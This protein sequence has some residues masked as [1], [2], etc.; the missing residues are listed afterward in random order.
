MLRPITRLDRR[1]EVLMV[2][3]ALAL[4]TFL[5]GGCARQDVRENSSVLIKQTPPTHNL[6]GIEGV[7]AWSGRTGR[8]MDASDTQGMLASADV[9]LVGE[10]HADETGH[11]VELALFEEVLRIESGTTLSMEMLERDEQHLVDR[12]LNGEIKTDD[13]VEQTHSANWGAT[14]RWGDWYQPVIDLAKKHNCPVVAANAPRR[15]VKRARREGYDALRALPQEERRWFCVPE[16]VLVGRYRERFEQKMVEHSMPSNL[17]NSRSAGPSSK[18]ML[19]HDAM[20]RSQLLWDCTMA[21][22]IARVLDEGARKVVHLVGEFHIAYDGGTL[23][24]L[25]RRKPDLTVCT[26]S[27][28]PVTAPAFRAKDK[29]RADVVIY[30]GSQETE[31]E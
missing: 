31:Q 26:I 3:V 4:V 6:F 19:S 1:L 23:Q 16:H 17:A 14:G 10:K 21:G 9:V 8:R 5:I 12:Y 30:T 7:T 11:R 29:G 25:R 22:S 15:Y 28:L 20:F 18:R 24:Y 13:F 27:M 2:P